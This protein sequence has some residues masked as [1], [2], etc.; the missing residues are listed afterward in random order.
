MLDKYY[1]KYIN[2]NNDILFDEFNN[3]IKLSFTLQNSDE[4]FISLDNILLFF[5]AIIIGI[6]IIYKKYIYIKSLFKIINNIKIF[7][8]NFD[9]YNFDNNDIS[10]VINNLIKI[11]EILSFDLIIDNLDVLNIEKPFDTEQLNELI[12][13]ILI[14]DLDNIYY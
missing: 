8:Y 14:L 2:I 3:S 12:E 13:K 4:Q 9:N 10:T 6:I 7:N 5:A 11:I 1:T